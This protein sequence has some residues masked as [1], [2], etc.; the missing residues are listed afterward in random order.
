VASLAVVIAFDVIGAFAHSGER[1]MATHTAIRDIGMGK[2]GRPTAGAMATL[3]IVAAGD[4][5][6]AFAGGHRTVVT[7]GAATFDVI[8][9]DLTA[10]IPREAVMARLTIFTAV[11]VPF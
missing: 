10:H 2:I 7:T 8:V 11:D 1:V 9:I 6:G 3:T 4:M 5:Q